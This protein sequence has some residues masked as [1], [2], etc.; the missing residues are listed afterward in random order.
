MLMVIRERDCLIAA[1][2]KALQRL[3]NE[4][5]SLKG[6]STQ[7]KHQLDTNLGIGLSE[8]EYFP[9]LAIEHASKLNIHVVTDTNWTSKNTCAT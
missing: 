2:L 3:L 4:G 6:H 5:W 7:C 1:V 9:L 8:A